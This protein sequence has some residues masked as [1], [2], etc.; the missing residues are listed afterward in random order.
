MLLAVKVE[1]KWGERPKWLAEEMREEGAENDSNVSGLE[2]DSIYRHLQAEIKAG[3][4]WNI[5]NSVLDM[6]YGD[7][8]T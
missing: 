6:L 5:A 4:W 8:K 7:G 2:T 3:F 1:T